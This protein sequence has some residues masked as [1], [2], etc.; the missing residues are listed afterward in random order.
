[1]LYACGS[2]RSD[3]EAHDEA[4]MTEYSRNLTIVMSENGRRSYL[5]D[6]PLVEG[7]SLAREPYREFREGI[8]ITTFQDDSLSTVDAV[9][10]ANYAIY[11]TNRELWEAKGDVEVRKSDGKEL[12]TQQLFWNA[13]SRRIYSNVDSRF[14]EGTRGVFVGEGFE[15]DEDFKDWRIRRQKGRVEMELKITEADSTATAG[16]DSLGG[17][18]APGR[19]PRPTDPRPTA[20]PAPAPGNGPAAS[21][22]AA[23]VPPPALPIPKQ[24]P[25][26]EH[27]ALREQKIQLDTTAL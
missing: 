23:A 4:V 5:F 15:S 8:R 16:R 20:S 3:G 25:R 14:V 6:T 21:A 7:Y 1:M 10:T 9:L 2:N 22:D 24:Q 11:Y 26:E 19:E 13:R 18:P 27:R 17:D 12:Y